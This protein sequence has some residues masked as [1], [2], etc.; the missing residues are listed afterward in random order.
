MV[1]GMSDLSIRQTPSVAIARTHADGGQQREST[2][3][4]RND[5]DR[6]R[7]AM[8][9]F[10][11]EQGVE[12]QDDAVAVLQMVTDRA[13]G[14]LRIRIVDERSGELYADLSAEEFAS[15]AS[16]HQLFEGLLVERE[17]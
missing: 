15:V 12:V 1:D 9:E 4:R 5:K 2:P 13:R 10:L 11:A 14:T 17:S 8:A 16:A 3:R 6:R 7:Q